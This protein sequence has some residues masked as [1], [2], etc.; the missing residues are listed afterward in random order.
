MAIALISSA[1]TRSTNGGVSVTS[2]P[3]NSTGANLLIAAVASYDPYTGI[4]DS[5]S[6]TWT[7]LILRGSAGGGCQLFWCVPTSVGTGH[8]ISNDTDFRYPGLAF[9]AISGAHA[10]PY[11]AESGA[12][13]SGSPG[14]LTPAQDGSL[15]FTAC[16]SNAHNPTVSGG[17][18]AQ[19]LGYSAG[20]AAAIAAA[21][22]IQGTAAPVNPAWSWE[23]G[24]AIGTAMAVF[25]PASPVATD[26]D[27]RIS[28]ATAWYVAGSG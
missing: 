12:G 28:P 19:G 22:L 2:D 6:N 1:I 24:G 15:L 9:Y 8:T 23:Y 5:K 10:S 26:P 20:N 14:S 7:P 21:Y 16:M 17:F 18:T 27:I 3:I 11:E 25:K 13:G 4:V